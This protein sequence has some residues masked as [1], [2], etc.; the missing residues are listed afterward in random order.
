MTAI[1]SGR[2][3]S[4]VVGVKGFDRSGFKIAT[5]S[6]SVKAK[7]LVSAALQYHALSDALSFT[8]S[9]NSRTHHF[10]F[11]TYIYN[12][13]IDLLTTLNRVSVVS[14]VAHY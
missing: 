2:I 5:N 10:Q 1:S 9:K 8:M 6:K 7:Q 12:S 4:R 11:M 3:S 14:R 13:S